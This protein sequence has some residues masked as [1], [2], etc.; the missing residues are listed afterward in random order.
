LGAENSGS[1]YHL[2]VE[3]TKDIKNYVHVEQLKPQF[4]DKLFEVTDKRVRRNILGAANNIP[5]A[6]VTASDGALFGTNADTYKQMKIFY[7]EQTEE[8]RGA[9]EQALT[10]IGFPTKIE[11]I[12]KP[13]TTP[14][15]Q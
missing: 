11:P 14:S 4:D 5:E 12:I 6:L 2:D 15:V 13:E 9:L 7:S 8:E 1:L 3:K 10:K